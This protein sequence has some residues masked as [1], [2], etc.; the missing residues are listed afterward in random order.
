MKK[1]LKKECVAVNALAIIPARGGSKGI[2]RKNLTLLAG[3]PLLA[4]TIECARNSKSINRVIV[5]TDDRDIAE[6]AQHYKSEV[7]MRPPEI[8]GD[9]ASSESALLHV[10]NHLLSS[11]HYEPE[12]IVFLQCTSPLTIPE[13][14]DGTMRILLDN[15]ADTALAVAP[16]HYFLWQKHKDGSAVGVGHDKKVR[17]LRQ[18]REPLFRETG[19]VYIMRTKGFKKAQHRFFGKTSLYVLPNERCVEIDNPEDFHIA[20]VLMRE[21]QKK[22]KIQALPDRIAMLVLDFDGIFTNNKVIVCEDGKEAVVCDRGDGWGISQLKKK[23]IPLLVLSTEKNPVV[24][25]RCEKLGIECIHGVDD[26]LSVLK[27]LF[28][29]RSIHADDVIYVGNDLNDLQCLQEVG[30]PVVP[31]DAHR[32]VRAA[33]RIIL[34]AYGGNGA[35]REI[36]ELI[37][38]KLE[39]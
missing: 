37:N 4:H 11:E 5:S 27:T 9:S 13:D 26:K 36:C 18:E 2:P 21:F 20:E 25:V 10:L 23:R 28:T 29:E 7:I 6:V 3:K 22:Q 12:I 31:R 15:D 16:F 17:L 38:Q 33:A 30:C 14:I 39:E 34:S 32:Q 8:S 19:G 24:K 35:I 1:N